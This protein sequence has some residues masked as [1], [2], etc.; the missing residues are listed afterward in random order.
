[1]QYADLSVVKHRLHL[2]A[3]LPFN[4][5]NA[6]KTLLL[7]RGQQVDSAEHLASLLE[8]GALVDLSELITPREEVLKA[9]RDQLPKLWSGAL[10]KLSAAMDTAPEPG[11]CD[12]LVEAAVPVQALIERDP[13]LAI[14]QVVQQGAEANLSYGAQRATQ[15]AITSMMVAQRMGWE[16]A[17]AELAFKVALTMN[18]SM[19]E[20]QGVLAKQS[21]PPTPEQRE[22]IRSHP[23]R[24]AVMLEQAGVTNQ[25][26][27]DAVR[28][29]HEVEDGSGYPGGSRSTAELSSLVR[30]ADVYTA[31]LSGRLARMPLS[32]D[33]AS[34]QMFMKDP[35]HAI[36]AALVKE[37]GIYPPGCMVKLASGETAMVIQRGTTITAPIVAC[38]TT[39]SGV[40]LSKP[41]R[42]DTGVRPNHVAGVVAPGTGPTPPALEKILQ[43]LAA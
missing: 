20:L 12:A 27:I 24:S 35:G 1:M 34:R 6:D 32:A 43:A 19:L 15:T 29:H 33:Q 30:R 11:F 38:L 37:F 13:D 18:L 7:A 5:R 23:E 41:V 3:P 26:W 42:I 4:V 31:K 8:R 22:A 36:T 2:G 9:R 21:Q 17:Q 16:P 40:P 25:A 10:T 14:F 28:H 39:P